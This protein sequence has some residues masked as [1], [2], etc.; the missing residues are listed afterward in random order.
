MLQ[1]DQKRDTETS[2]KFRPLLK[3]DLGSN[4]ILSTRPCLDLFRRS[5]IKC[6]ISNPVEMNTNLRR[7]HFSGKTR[8]SEE[9]HVDAHY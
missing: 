2:V 9:E 1:S 4:L 8:H 7:G 3:F 5:D 6:K